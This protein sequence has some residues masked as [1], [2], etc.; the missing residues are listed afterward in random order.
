MNKENG[1][2]VLLPS[3]TVFVF[4]LLSFSSFPPYCYSPFFQTH[5]DN[6]HRRLPPRRRRPHCATPW[7][8]APPHRPGARALGCPSDPYSDIS[9]AIAPPPHFTKNYL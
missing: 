9:N 8:P 4:A 6:S 3:P 1:Q 2:L 7:S 5:A